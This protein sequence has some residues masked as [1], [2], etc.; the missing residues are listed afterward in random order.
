VTP[1]AAVL[2]AAR[3]LAG[4]LLAIA[5]ILPATGASW[6]FSPR[7]E[8]GLTWTVSTVYANAALGKRRPE[9][10]PR[11]TEWSPATSWMYHVSKVERREGVTYYLVQVK[12]R[13]HESS[14]LASLVF[15]TFELSDGSTHL[16]LLR[17]KFLKQVRNERV[18]TE[19]NENEPG[20]APRPVLTE[21]SIIPY[22]FPVMPLMKASAGE[23]RRRVFEVTQQLDSMAFAKDVVQ[24]DQIGLD[25][26]RFSHGE[27]ARRS[28]FADVPRNSMVFVELS[29][30]FDGY[31][32]RQVW[33]PALPWPLYSDNGTSRSV[34]VY[35][36]KELQSEAPRRSTTSTPVT[37]SATSP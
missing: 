30:D 7:W 15:G 12:D 37:T 14:A 32:C 11:K 26:D 10:G 16:A 28:G 1:R 34:L 17:G 24:L 8:A 23:A 29:R 22:D 9:D 3:R 31:R 5:S 36:S 2:S 20:Q 6:A 35:H 13:E 4:L 19:M 27:I 33:S 25:P 21:M 18:L